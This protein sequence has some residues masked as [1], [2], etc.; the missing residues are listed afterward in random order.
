ML[1]YNELFKSYR[2]S[3]CLTLEEIGHRI[4]VS[5]Q[6]V[7]KWE[8]GSVKPRPDKVYALAEILNLSVVDISD[9]KPE[10]W[11]I[12]ECNR[13]ESGFEDIEMFRATLINALID[14]DLPP[15]ALQKVLKIVRNHKKGE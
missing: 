15:E 12:D 1:F 10:K 8:T 13:N 2:Q 5:K 6:T 9:L 7:Q 14:A 11:L 3:R 4:G